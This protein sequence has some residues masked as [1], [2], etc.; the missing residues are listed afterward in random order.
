M[1]RNVF[2]RNIIVRASNKTPAAIRANLFAQYSTK[3]N[4]ND[5]PVSHTEEIQ[6]NGKK[7]FFCR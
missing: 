3:L 5:F 4:V 7:V 6:P 1:L 2:A